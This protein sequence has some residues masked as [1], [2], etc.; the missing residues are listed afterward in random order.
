MSFVGVWW[1]AGIPE[2]APHAQACWR[3]DK[4]LSRGPGGM[5]VGGGLMLEL[6]KVK[7]SIE[8]NMFAQI[9]TSAPR[10]EVEL[11]TY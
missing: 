7:S 11:G 8:A 3:S 10:R 4:F 1:W 2:R 5:V 6:S 9:D